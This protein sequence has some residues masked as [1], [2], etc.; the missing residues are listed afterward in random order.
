MSFPYT[1]LGQLVPSHRG[2]QVS[3]VPI[4]WGLSFSRVDTLL[5]RCAVLPYGTDPI[6]FFASLARSSDDPAHVV[7]VS[8]DSHNVPERY[9]VVNSLFGGW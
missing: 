8:A 2:E 7:V 4:D 3:E 1:R 9:S 6:Q 5:P